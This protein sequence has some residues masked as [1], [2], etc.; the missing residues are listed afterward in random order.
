MNRVPTRFMCGLR[1][2]APGSLS[3]RKGSPMFHIVIRILIGYVM[4]GAV[5]VF[6]QTAE[7]PA[8]CSD[9]EFRQL[10]FWVGDWDLKWDGGAGRNVVTSDLGGCVVTENFDGTPS[11]PLKGTSV[12]IYNK[13]SGLWQQTW[14]DNQGSYLD[15]TGGFRDSKMVLQREAAIKDKKVLQRMVFYDIEKDTLKWNWERSADDGTTWKVMWKIEY[16]RRPPN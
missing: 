3:E 2:Q 4:L 9:P 11:S 6:S 5:P 7:L 16:T 14:V 1:K 10:D 13:R 12:S 15:F 8:P